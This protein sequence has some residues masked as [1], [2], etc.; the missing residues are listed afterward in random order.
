MPWFDD[1]VEAIGKYSAVLRDN[2]EDIRSLLYRGE[3]YRM[4]RQLPEAIADFSRIIDRVSLATEDSREALG[5]LHAHICRGVAHVAAG[6]GEAAFADF[7]TAIEVDPDYHLGYY[8]RGKYWFATGEPTKAIDDHTK[9][10]E[11]DSGFVPAYLQR[12]IEWKWIREFEK[13]NADFAVVRK[14]NNQCTGPKIGAPR[15]T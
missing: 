15:K 1:P 2:D 12:G 7:N 9:T 5:L 10:I 13:A 4:Q 14:Y 6:N 11:L 8:N 3:A